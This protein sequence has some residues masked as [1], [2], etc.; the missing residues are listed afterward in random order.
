MIATCTSGRIAAFMAEPHPG[1]RGLRGRAGGLFQ[2]HLAR[3]AGRRAV[4]L[5]IDEVQTGWGRTG[6]YWC[7]IEHWGVE[8]DVITFAKGIANGA[9]SG[10]HR[11][12]A[13]GGGGG[14]RPHLI[15]LWRQT[16]WR[17]RRL[18]RRWSTSRSTGFGRTRRLGVMNFARGMEKMQEAHP[19][20]GDVRGMGLM[21]AFEMV[22][23]DGSKK[24]DGGSSLRLSPT[25]RASTGCSSA[26]ADFTATRFGLRRTST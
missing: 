10:L 25:P 24:P 15:D 21:Q 3:G 12:H 1:R 16:R 20:I 9:P 19:F 14:G 5:I 17:W 18:T 23:P 4:C 6:R 13:R 22:V 8:P 26:R 2:A 7:G 11:R